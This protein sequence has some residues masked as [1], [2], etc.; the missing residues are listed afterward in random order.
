MILL[1][2]KIYGHEM[3]LLEILNFSFLIYV[4]TLSVFEL[5]FCDDPVIINF[6]SLLL[7]ERKQFFFVGEDFS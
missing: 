2:V 5:F 6:L 7:I 1:F 4:V 3:I